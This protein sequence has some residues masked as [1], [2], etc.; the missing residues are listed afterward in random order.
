MTA[1]LTVGGLLY[2][3]AALLVIAFLVWDLRGP[4]TPE[5]DEDWLA[6]QPHEVDTEALMH[7]EFVSIISANWHWTEDAQ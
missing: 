4:C 5:P 2:L 1:A 7:A 3:A 6:D